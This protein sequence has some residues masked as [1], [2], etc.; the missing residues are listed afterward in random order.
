MGWRRKQQ[1][2]K[3]RASTSRPLCASLVPRGPVLESCKVAAPQHLAFLFLGFL[4]P[5]T[6]S[7]PEN[8]L[9]PQLNSSRVVWLIPSSPQSSSPYHVDSRQAALLLGLCLPFCF[10]ATVRA[11][12]APCLATM[13]TPFA[14]TTVN[15][16]TSLCNHFSHFL[17]NSYLCGP[18]RR[19][20]IRLSQRSDG[21]SVE[22]VLSSTFMWAP[23]TKLRWSGLCRSVCQPSHL[24]R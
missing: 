20:H 11:I 22:F 19:G 12:A 6:S 13:A 5:W 18:R 16:E 15:F 21:N 9:R 23:G 4:G 17:K 24:V 7:S 14:L 10:Q 1:G 2:T 3:K 8:R